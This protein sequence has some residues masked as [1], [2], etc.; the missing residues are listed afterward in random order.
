V[1]VTEVLTAQ[2]GGA[3]GMAGDFDVGTAFAFYEL[4]GAPL[5]LL[6]FDD[7]VSSFQLEAKPTLR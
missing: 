7:E 2:S 1:E 4:H 3:A 5:E 6:A